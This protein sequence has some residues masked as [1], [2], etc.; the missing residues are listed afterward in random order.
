MLFHDDNQA[1]SFGR[2]Y[3]AARFPV[4]PP[5]V[6]LASYEA[7]LCELTGK[8][9]F[10][11]EPE[12]AAVRSMLSHLLHYMMA[13]PASSTFHHRT[14]G[15]LFYH[16][17]EVAA[18][19]AENVSSDGD[20]DDGMVLAAFLGGLLHDIGKI[21]TYFAVSKL[22]RLDQDEGFG[23]PGYDPH[24][25]AVWKPSEGSLW[26]WCRANEVM[27]LALEY[28]G[29]TAGFGH[30][31]AGAQL[32]RQFLPAALADF[33]TVR[34]PDALAALT[35]YLDRKM[36]S[37]P[38]ARAIKAA[39]RESVDRDVNARRR[40]GPKRSDLHVVRRFIEYASLCAWNRRDA[41][42]VMADIW[43]DGRDTGTALPFFRASWFHLYAFHDYLMAEDLY[44][45]A[46]PKKGSLIDI[47][48]K[49]EHYGILSRTVP[50]L[51]VVDLAPYRAEEVPAFTAGLLFPGD[52]AEVLAEQPLSWFPLGTRMIWPGL[53]EA[54]V[55]L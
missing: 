2:Y 35:R 12:F 52:D 17:L 24:A 38:L 13:L 28:T 4:V 55:M 34:D 19:A 40:W 22:D 32:W 5:E 53:P 18:L 14:S 50:A 37:H 43:V 48:E 30:D 26:D 44:G 20:A 31:A 42:F 23:V 21:A 46:I 11:G 51:P 6:T 47:C 27:Y 7:L 10:L 3:R 8:L 54:R 29:T 41:P 15:G 36:F 1:L 39:D 25:R 33:L 45:C 9:G 49:L 16:S